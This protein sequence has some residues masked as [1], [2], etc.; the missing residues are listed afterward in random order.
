VLVLHRDDEVVVVDKPSGWLTHPSD[1]AGPAPAVLGALRDLVGA[2][3]FPVH[4][5]DRGAS[6][7]LLF[8]LSSPA[9]RRLHEAFEAGAVDK[10]YLALVRGT[11]P[12]E[13]VVDSPVPQGEDGPR[14]PALTEVRRLAVVRVTFAG[15]RPQAYSLVEARPR[16]GRF[17][18]IRRHLKHLGHPLLGDVNYGRG[19]HN[20]F[21]RAE[22]GLSRLALHATSL[23]W[24]GAGGVPISV[25]APLGDDLRAPL[26][27]MGFSATLLT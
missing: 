17:H 20:R 8:A 6:G 9:A 19:E 10:R 1:F 22:F 7:A 16:T 27:A 18:Q 4:R 21:V 2:H 24:E 3:V 15:G 5:L 12:A 23:T 14:V 13:T 26:A 25:R 11:A